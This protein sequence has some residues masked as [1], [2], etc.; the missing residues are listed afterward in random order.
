MGLC[1]QWCTIR[2]LALGASSISLKRGSYVEI[3]LTCQSASASV[4][5][6]PLPPPEPLEYI[7]GSCCLN[8]SLKI[9]SVIDRHERS[10]TPGF[11]PHC[12]YDAASN[13]FEDSN[14]FLN[15]GFLTPTCNVKSAFQPLHP[16]FDWFP[17]HKGRNCSIPVYE[18]FCAA[19]IVATS[20]GI[21]QPNIHWL[22]ASIHKLI[23]RDVVFCFHFLP[24]GIDDEISPFSFNLP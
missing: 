15:S 11:P 6:P 4:D 16:L 3:R 12:P 10:S 8:F 5:A 23:Q 17:F 7:K 18:T 1:S 19:Q 2:S 22:D 20:S 24:V 13:H 14:L 21:D 9:Y